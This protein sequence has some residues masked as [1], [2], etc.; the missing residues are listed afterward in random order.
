MPFLFFATL[1]HSF[2]TFSRKFPLFHY[3]FFCVT[4]T[5]TDKP[6]SSRGMGYGRVLSGG[7]KLSMADTSKST[8]SQAYRAEVGT[9]AKSYNLRACAYVKK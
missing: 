9:L 1:K 4:M 5:K 6:L 2:F 7:S 8:D 3:F